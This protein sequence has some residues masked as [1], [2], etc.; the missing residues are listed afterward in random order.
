MVKAVTKTGTLGQLLYRLREWRWPEALQSLLDDSMFVADADIVAA[1]QDTYGPFKCKLSTP[2]E[3]SDQLHKGISKLIFFCRNGERTRVKKAKLL[4]PELEVFS[5]TYDLAGVSVGGGGYFEWEQPKAE[6]AQKNPVVIIAP[7]G[8]DVEYFAETLRRNN[9][10]DAREYVNRTVAT[11]AAEQDDFSLLRFLQGVNKKHGR[12][13]LQLILYTDVLEDLM[14]YTGFSFDRFLWLAK[15]SSVQV[16]FFTRRDKSTQSAL[17]AQLDEEL[18]RSYWASGQLAQECINDPELREDTADQFLNWLL[19]IEARIEQQLA[20]LKKFKYLT[21][22]ETVES[23]VEVTE[24]I[25]NYLGRPVDGEVE[26]PE[27]ARPYKKRPNLVK[28]ANNYRQALIDR[29][30]LRMNEEGSYVSDAELITKN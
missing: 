15:K 14:R 11:W 13:Q 30:G 26:W 23:P 21:L 12:E 18:G 9:V 22:E 8:S 5:A 16:L 1:L 2:D 25:A 28:F 19:R 10:C 3:Y 24:A 6:E 4:Y 7:P 27:Y 29:L 17:L 20:K